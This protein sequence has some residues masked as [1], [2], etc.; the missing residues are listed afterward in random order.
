MTHTSPL[1]ATI[2]TAARD[3]V[4]SLI[5]CCPDPTEKKQR[6]LIARDHGH[7]SDDEAEEWIVLAGLEAA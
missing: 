7:L 6:I 3:F 5:H 4:L 2:G 1:A